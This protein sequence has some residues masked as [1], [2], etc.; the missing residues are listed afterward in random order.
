MCTDREC[1][2]YD[3]QMV[4]ERAR[5]TPAREALLKAGMELLEEQHGD[6]S[7]VKMSEAVNRAGVT[8]GAFY[9]LWPQGLLAYQE[10]LLRFAVD[11][12]RMEYV[13]GMVSALREVVAADPPAMSLTDLIHGFAAL[14]AANLDADKEYRVWIALWARHFG[15]PSLRQKLG[16]SYR[17]LAGEYETVYEELLKGF[18]LQLRPPFSTRLLATALTAMAEG[19]CL[20]RTVDPEAV[21]LP[22]GSGDWEVFGLL[23]LLVTAMVTKKHDSSDTRDAWELARDMLGIL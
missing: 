7:E 17:G 16:D 23:I 5:H 21:A 3:Q 15:D 4:R 10:D 18:G 13:Q 9:H 2:R 12:K 20:R 8:N 19:L 1:V 22:A 6:I 11:P 14:D